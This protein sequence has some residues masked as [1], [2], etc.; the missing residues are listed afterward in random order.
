[1]EADHAVEHGIHRDLDETQFAQH[2]RQLL[3]RIEQVQRVDEIL[4]EAGRRRAAADDQ[5]GEVEAGLEVGVVEVLHDRIARAQH[6][7]MV[8][9]AAGLEH[10][11]D[12]AEHLAHAQ[13]ARGELQRDDVEVVVGEG[14][15]MHV[16][17]GALDREAQ[18]FG[19]FLAD[20]LHLGAAIHGMHIQRR[21]AL[22]QGKPMALVPAQ[23]SSTFCCGLMSTE[24]HEALEEGAPEAERG[25][26]VGAVVIARDVG[27]GVVQVVVPEFAEA[28]FAYRLARGQRGWCHGRDTPRRPAP[29]IE[30]LLK[31]G[32]A[33][34]AGS[35]PTRPGRRRGVAGRPPAA[36]SRRRRKCW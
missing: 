16:A 21:F 19:V 20:G 9:V 18:G 25:D 1:V 13:V 31:P 23:T 17:D 7:R 27:E 8:E 34:P 10:A 11:Q 36:R 29:E 6:V 35:H 4:L 32:C 14:Q 30:T 22:E 33:E 5:A 28:L 3:R 15:H 26:F 12:L 24:L 2:D